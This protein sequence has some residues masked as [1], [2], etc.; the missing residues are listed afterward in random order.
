MGRAALGLHIAERVQLRVVVF[1][2]PARI[3]VDDVFDLVHAFLHL[4]DLVHLLLVAG[5]DEARAAML[6]HIGH[7]FGDGVLVERHGD[8]ADLLRRDHRPVERGAV[9]SDDRDMVAALDAQ[10]EESDGDRLDFLGGFRPGPGLPDAVFLF[11]IGRLGAELRHV[12]L[13]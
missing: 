2:E 7:L 5:D 11:A 4:D 1:P 6:Q 8:R 9:A 3:L 12:A 13:Q 10:R